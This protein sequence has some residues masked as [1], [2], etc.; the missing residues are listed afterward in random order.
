MLDAV[1]AACAS[2]RVAVPA[3]TFRTLLLV[4]YGA[5]LRL[6]EALSLTVADVDLDQAILCVRGVASCP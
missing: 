1:P 2:D 5:G 4:L 3:G 6:G